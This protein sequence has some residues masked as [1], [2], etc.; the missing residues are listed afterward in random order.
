MMLESRLITFADIILHSKTGKSNSE[1]RP[2]GVQRL[3]QLDSAAIGQP[4]IANEHVKFLLR[5]QI[6]CGLNV[7]SRLHIIATPPKQV[8]KRSVGVFVILDKYYAHGVALR[9]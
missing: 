4:K 6:A 3:H 5:A 2:R 7:A 1:K 9:R 8:R